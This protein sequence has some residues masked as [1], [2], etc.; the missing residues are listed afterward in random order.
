MSIRVRS[1]SQA[2]KLMLEAWRREMSDVEVVGESS[3][4]AIVVWRR[5]LFW[6]AVWLC[7]FVFVLGGYLNEVSYVGV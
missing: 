6:L 5:S 3:A 4:L 2:R 1:K 7:I